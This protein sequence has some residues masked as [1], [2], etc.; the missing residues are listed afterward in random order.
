MCTTNNSMLTLCQSDD[1]RHLSSNS[2]LHGSADLHN[3]ASRKAAQT[4]S[5]LLSFL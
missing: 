3:P 5:S 1:S 2:K 4:D